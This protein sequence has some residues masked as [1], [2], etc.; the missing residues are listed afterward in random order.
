MEDIGED[1]WTTVQGLDARLLHG[2]QVDTKFIVGILPRLVGEG[3]FGVKSGA[4]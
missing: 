3:A 2:S 4:T 1:K